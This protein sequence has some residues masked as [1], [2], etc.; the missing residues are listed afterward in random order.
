MDAR[1]IKVLLVEDSVVLAERLAEDIAEHAEF[2]LI[3]VVDNEMAALQAIKRGRVDVVLLDL[4]L[5]SG[6]GFGVLRGINA[7][8]RRPQ[9]IILTNHDLPEYHSAAVRLGVTEFLDKARAVHRLPGTL[10]EMVQ[11][12]ATD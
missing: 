11:A 12:L 5:K 4:Q 7:L 1:S 3:G 2:D 6:S 10:R 8:P 9:V